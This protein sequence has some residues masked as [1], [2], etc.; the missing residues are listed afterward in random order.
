MPEK[1]RCLLIDPEKREVSE[2]S[3]AEGRMVAALGDCLPDTMRIADHGSSY[4][5]G[6][7]DDTGLSR[8][9]PIHA[10]QFI[11]MSDDPIAGKCLLYGATKF[12]GET[13]DAKFNIDTLR[14]VVRWLGLIVPKVEWTKE[15]N[16]DRAKVTWERYH[17]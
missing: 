7:V 6:M 1:F 4:D 14:A 12:G 17:V 16:V 3:C 2:I 10:F 8:G 9:K 13:C 11:G 5:Y 15:G